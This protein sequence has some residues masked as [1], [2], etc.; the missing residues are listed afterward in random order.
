MAALACQ[1]SR[2][3]NPALWLDGLETR[4]AWLY[5]EPPRPMPAGNP[6]GRGKGGYAGNAWFGFDND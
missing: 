1:D 5:M 2:A 6:D 3:E 4:A